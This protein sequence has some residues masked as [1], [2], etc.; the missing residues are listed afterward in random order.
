MPDRNTHGELYRNL[1]LCVDT[2]E[3]G[4]LAGR[5][6]YPGLESGSMVFHSLVELLVRVEDLLDEAK[7]PQSYT[8]KRFFVPLP[9][10][11]SDRNA[12]ELM[13]QAGKRATFVVRLLFRQHASW[14]GSVIWLEGKG[15][16]NFR[17]VLELVLLLNNALG[18]CGEDVA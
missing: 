5:L 3:N 17:S 11:F 2:Y 8:A 16:Q 1:R 4:I 6:Y 15:E 18:G 12:P 10:D 14:Q 13:E 7:F 9:K